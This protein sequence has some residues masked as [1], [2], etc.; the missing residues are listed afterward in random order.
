VRQTYRDSISTRSPTDP[1]HGSGVIP[2]RSPKGLRPGAE[3]YTSKEIAEKLFISIKTV[4]GYRQNILDKLG[5]R[6]RVE[7]TRYA[8]KRG[9]I[10]P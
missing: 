10:Q 8:I 9:L 1:D 3:A 6:D 5:I 7:L 4:D 2:E